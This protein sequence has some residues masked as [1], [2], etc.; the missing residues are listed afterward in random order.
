MMD[1][2]NEEH[3]LVREMIQKL[4]REKVMRRAA[5][6]DKTEEYPWD[7]HRLFIDNGLFNIRVPEKYGGAEMDY[8]S[9]CIVVEEL[10]K[11]DG[12]CA[13][14]VAHHQAGMCCFM[15]GANEVQKEKYLPKIGRGDYLVGFAMTEPNSGSDAFS[16]KTRATMEDEEYVINGGKC[17]ISNGGITDLYVLFT[18]V[19]PTQRR[20]GITAFL[21]EKETR[22]LIVGKN[23]NKMGFRASPT[24]ELTFDNMRVPKEN[25]L[26]KIGKGWELVLQSLTET[27]VLVAAMALGI[28]QGAMEAA[29]LYAKQRE[30]F[31]QPIINFQGV[32]FMLADMAIQVECARAL[33]YKLA[34]MVDQGERKL[35]YYASVAKC[36]ASDMAMKV[37]TDAVQVL[38]GYGYT[39][40]FPVEKM[41][42]DAKATQIIEG[43]NQIQRIQIMRSLMKMY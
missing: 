10:A 36:F 14:S 28:A 7:L 17:F 4:C 19:N 5:E 34:A 21:V 37:T 9:A 18:T 27:R 26:G 41:M 29:I 25:L 42:R 20:E 13:N 30:Q 24:R 1:T 32:S 23:E 12:A 3:K 38:G 6:A 16:L 33:I 35:H 11:V 22:G 39:S 2:F 31:G 43:T 15:D 40:E 8:T